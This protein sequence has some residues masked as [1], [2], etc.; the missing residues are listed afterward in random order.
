MQT[1]QNPVGPGVEEEQL[2]RAAAC[3]L[4]FGA[5]MLRSGTVSHRVREGIFRLGRAMGLPRIT[6]NLAFDA[7]TL[8]V[9]ENGRSLTSASRVS[10]FGINAY[11]LGMLEHLAAN[12]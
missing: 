9:G 7:I 11:R 1:I 6:V 8:S 10:G 2:V 12:A 5:T 4:R 3:L